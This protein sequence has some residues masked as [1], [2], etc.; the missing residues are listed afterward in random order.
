MVVLTWLIDNRTD[1]TSKGRTGP[2]ILNEQIFQD[3]GELLDH[4]QSFLTQ[5]SLKHVQIKMVLLNRTRF[6]IYDSNFF[7]I[8][9][10]K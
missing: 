2:T 8:L 7:K 6:Y 4:Y 9:D 1:L 5:K 3:K 10:R